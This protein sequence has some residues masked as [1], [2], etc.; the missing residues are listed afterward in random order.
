LKTNITSSICQSKKEL[1][2]DANNNYFC[3]PKKLF[4][5]VDVEG[6]VVIDMDDAILICKKEKSQDVKS[7][8]DYL[9]RKKGENCHG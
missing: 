2:L 7:I 1:L 6:L 9:N 8:V 3:S 5:A 4:V